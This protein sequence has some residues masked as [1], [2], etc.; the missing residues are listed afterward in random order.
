[1]SEVLR[2]EEW[3]ILFDHLSSNP[4]SFLSFVVIA[5]LKYFR[6]ALLK[7]SRED[8]E[9]NI[10]LFTLP[11]LFILFCSFSYIILMQMTSTTSWDLRITIFIFIIPLFPFVFVLVLVLFSCCW[12]EQVQS[13]NSNEYEWHSRHQT[14][15][16]TAQGP[17]PHLQQ[18]SKTKIKLSNAW[19]WTNT[20]TRGSLLGQKTCWDI[21]HCANS[22]VI[23]LLIYI[24]VG[25]QCNAAV[26]GCVTKSSA[27]P[28]TFCMANNYSRNWS[29]IFLKK[30]ILVY[31][32]LL[33]VCYQIMHMY[34]TN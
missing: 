34:T 7:S 14:I 13:K 12:L 23:Y 25:L 5:F 27:E 32:L 26:E 30:I 1:M 28:H 9:V 24:Y 33:V 10:F 21:V 3:Q 22:Y 31:Q 16:T 19:N 17:V 6:S 8:F 4:T 29:T 18:N 15:S 2:T 20:Q 11:Y